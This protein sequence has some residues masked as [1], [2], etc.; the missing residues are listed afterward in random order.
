MMK[1]RYL[2]VIAGVMTV[3]SLQAQTTIEQLFPGKISERTGILVQEA[4]CGQ[5]FRQLPVSDTENRARLI[6]QLAF[7]RRSDRLAVKSE[8]EIPEV[9]ATEKKEQ[10]LRSV[11]PLE[12]SEQS[13]V[14]KQKVEDVP[15]KQVSVM[16]TE[17]T[18]LAPV[19]S[20]CII[21][22]CVL[23]KPI[24]NVWLAGKKMKLERVGKYYRYI[25]EYNN[26]EKARSALKEVK[27]AFPDAFIRKD[28]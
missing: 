9:K 24:G 16:K 19:V 17:V 22:V 26:P 11:V 12:Q 1:T 7:Q 28:Q 23:S 2:F 4:A 27:K 14:V 15:V 21:Q 8:N 18:P 13:V 20:L 5:A 6:K 3:T 25:L 10:E